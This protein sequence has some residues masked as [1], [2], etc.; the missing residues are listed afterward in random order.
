MAGRMYTVSFAPTAV[1]VAADLFEIRPAA[2]KPVEVAGLFISQTTEIAD[3][4]DEMIGYSVVRGHSTSG[5]GTATTPRPLDRSATAA[6]FAAET[7]GTTQASAG[8][9]VTLH[10]DAFNVRSGLGLWLPEDCQ[11]EVS[12]TDTTLVVRLAGAPSDSVSFTG[13]LYVRE[14]G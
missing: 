14:W 13:T 2:E 1:T 5:N 8:T 4:Q 10:A 3:A 9:G 12:A 6:G 7:V 11:W